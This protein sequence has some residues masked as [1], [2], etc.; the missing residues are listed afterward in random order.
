EVL[1]DGSPL[2][3]VELDALADAKRRIVWLRGRRVRTDA[4]VVRR[5]RQVPS[6][7]DGP[8]GLAAALAGEVVDHDGTVVQVIAEGFA[9]TVRIRLGDLA[10]VREE[11]EPPGLAATLRPYQRRGVAWMADLCRSGLGGVLAD[12]MGLGKTVQVIALHLVLSESRPIPGPMLVVCPTSVLGNWAREI[13]RFAPGVPVRKLSGPDR[14]L[15][16]LAADE[17]VLVTYGVM[18]RMVDELAEVGWT[19]VVADEAQ[20]IKNPRA[21]TAR[22]IR[23]IPSEARLALTGTPVENRLS[24]L[25][26]LLDWTTPGLL[27][28]SDHFR[29]EFAVPIERSSDRRRRQRLAL[30]TKPFML[31]RRKTDD[32][33]ATD[34]PSRTQHDVMAPLTVEQLSM[35]EALVRESL[36]QINGSEGATRVGMVFRLLTALKQI[37]NHPGQYLHENDGPLDGRSGKLDATVELVGAAVEGEERVLVFSQYVEMCHLLRRRFHEVDIDAEVLHGGLSADARDRLVARFQAGEI[38]VLVISL[39]AGGT[40]LNLT[41]ANHVIHLDRWW[42]PAVENQ[43]TDRAFRIGQRRSVQVRKFVCTGTLEEKIDQMIEDKKALADLV[44]GDGEGWLTELSSGDL[45]KVFALS[46]GAIGE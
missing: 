27:G 39:K 25:W 18:R 29:T 6:G 11:P 9:D 41:A 43:A 35:Y 34:L 19:V 33:V 10:G 16:G 45:R 1:C 26:A 32:G 4:D 14:H 20:T 21:R 17:I 38:P 8:S 44:V 7:L 13:A 23:R 36:F 24:E 37:A 31:R 15:R 40:G 5:I 46:D 28:S 2:T 30:L 42:N 3:D 12:D 22:A